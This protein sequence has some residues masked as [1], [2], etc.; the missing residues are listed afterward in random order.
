M[1]TNTHSKIFT[2]SHQFSASIFPDPANL[3]K[4][5]ACLHSFD[6]VEMADGYSFSEIES[7][8]H[9]L[10][11]VRRELQH[12]NSVSQSQSEQTLFNDTI[13]QLGLY[14]SK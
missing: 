6:V 10:L 1:I 4:H 9:F 7:M 3:G 13:E 2:D 11:E 8:I 5:I 14:D 12:K